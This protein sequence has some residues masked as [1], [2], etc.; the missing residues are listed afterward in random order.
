MEKHWKIKETPD[1]RLV[2]E[3]ASAT[4]VSPILSSLLL[5]R[6]INTPT[7][8]QDFFSPDISK[9]HDP[10]LFCDMAKAVSRVKKALANGERIL[11]YGDYDVDG[12]T[13]VALVHTALERFCA[14]P[15]SQLGY[16]IPDRY[17][18]GY[19][20]SQKGVEYAHSGGYSLVIALDC[21]IKAVERM[22]YARSLGIDFIICDHHTPGEVIPDVV[23]CLN[24]KR[25]DCNYPDKNLSGCGVG[26]KLMQ[27]LYRSKGIADEELMPLLDL[28][29][30]SIA[31][32]IVPI[33]GENRILAHNGLRQLNTT[34]RIGLR[35]II[36][37]AGL[38]EG[39]IGMG[40]IVFKLGPR[41][42]AAGRM[43]S[44]NEAVRI[45]LERD[46]NI[47]DELSRQINDS[48]DERKD[49]DRIVTSQAIDRIESQDPQHTASSTVLYDPEWSKGVIGI[50]ASRLTETYYRPTIILTRSQA[51]PDYA[52]GSARSIDGFDLYKAI[53]ACSDLLENFGGHTYAAGLTMKIENV[54]KFATAFEKY[55]SQNL[56]AEQRCQQIDIDA[57]I[58]LADV[59][60]ALLA[61]LQ[62]L[63]PFGSANTKPVFMTRGIYDYSTSKQF[64]Q[65]Q[66]HLKLDLI[67]ATDCTIRSGVGFC[68]GHLHEVLS[69]GSK[70]DI[71]YTIEENEFRGKKQLQLM[72]KDLRLSE[73]DSPEDEY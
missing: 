60:P 72:V 40:D 4:H 35:S 17:T 33:I 24:S 66:Q 61:E 53:D 36:H 37:T 18:E 23:A 48:N 32:D 10:M 16:Y 31:S 41:I 58:K 9:L 64:G 26:F 70:V 45:L 3:F 59:K 62:S 29:V 27:A 5:Q 50:V 73:V 67:D 54:D 71:C 68:L 21:G 38:T 47:A 28:V 55:A 14:E 8:A 52:T 6:G 56:T 39:N 7:L 34:P 13:A 63:E 30:V 49:L 15:N 1:K 42:N 51:N 46:A 57:E 20:I 65:H 44:G 12:T 2:E 22:K 43:R 19:G 25:V 69:S 11:I